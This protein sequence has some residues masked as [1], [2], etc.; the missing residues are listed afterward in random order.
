MH[1]QKTITIIGAGLVGCEFANDLVN[2]GYE[3]TII[4]P[5]NYPLARLV[6]ED[7]GLAFKKAF[8]EKGV[9]WRLREFF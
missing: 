3:V 4:A 6:P 9:I 5:D 8:A 2:I 1:N 7:I